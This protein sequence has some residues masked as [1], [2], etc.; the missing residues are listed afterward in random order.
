MGQ[1]ERI[2]R[3]VKLHDIRVLMSVVEAGSSERL[4]RLARAQFIRGGRGS[5]DAIAASSAK[6]G[7]L[8]AALPP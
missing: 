3:R 8:T 6:A 1:I 4:G 7:I 5:A 2:E